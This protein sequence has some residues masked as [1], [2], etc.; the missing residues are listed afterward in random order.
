MISINSAATILLVG[1]VFR[2]PIRPVRVNL[3]RKFDIFFFGVS[4]IQILKLN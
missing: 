4:D 3:N 1:C 2:S